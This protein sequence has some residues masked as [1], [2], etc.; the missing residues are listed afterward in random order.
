MN[1]LNALGTSGNPSWSWAES[2]Y[3]ALVTASTIGFGDLAPQ[4]PAARMFG[5][6]FLPLA[7]AAAGELFSA[8]ALQLVQHRQQ[9]VF[10]QELRNDL[11]MGHLKAMDANGD[12]MITREEYVAFMLMEMGR[13]DI[14][15]LNELHAQFE[16]LDVLKSGYLD[17]EDIK[18]IAQLRG[19]GVKE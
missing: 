18:V 9:I 17:R 16:T 4:T 19:R 10:E 5:V 7:V 14:H 8:V 11:N 3:F 13:V 6:I 12:G 15:E 2:I 1:F